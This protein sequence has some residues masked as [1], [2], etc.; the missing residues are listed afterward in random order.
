MIGTAK[1]TKVVS[2]F[3]YWATQVIWDY[4]N[5]EYSSTILGF[6]N[7]PCTDAN[8]RTD[9]VVD[10]I[11]FFFWEETTDGVKHCKIFSGGAG[12]TPSGDDGDAG[13]KGG[14]EWISVLKDGKL[15]RVQHCNPGP[16]YYT[17]PTPCCIIESIDVDELGH[18]R[19]ITG[20]YGVVP[21]AFSIGPDGTN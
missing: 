4:T 8:E 5:E 20:T 2:G 21:E 10:D 18:V 15:D 11:V 1:V 9:R 19:E 7:E 17:T 6:E 12:G 3:K 13:T 14:N 16:S